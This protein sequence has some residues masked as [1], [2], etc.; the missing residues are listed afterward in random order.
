[1]LRII[2]AAASLFVAA[3]GVVA[4]MA[5][6][7]V[8]QPLATTGQT[9]S[10]ATAMILLAG[11]ALLAVGVTGW[12]GRP[13]GILG[14]LGF[15][16][17]AAW[18][19]PEL[20]GSASVT[21]EARSLGLLLA[22][23]FVPLVAH[24]PLR[25]LRVDRPGSLTG[26]LLAAAYGLVLVGAVGR[27]LTYD[28]F[29]EVACSPVCTRGDNVLAIHVE[30]R[31]AST[32]GTIALVASTALAI[33]LMAW[34]FVRLIRQSRSDRRR[35]WQ[36]L[37]PTV[38][39]GVGLGW[40]GLARIVV[41]GDSPANTWMLL[42]A[43]ITAASVTAL[44]AGV[45]WFLMTQL[46]QAD[47]LH[48]MAELMALESA[49][50]LR[51][52]LA[53][54][55]GDPELRVVYPLETRGGYVDE[56]GNVV[57]EPRRGHGR[58]VTAIERDG[59]VVAVVEHGASLDPELL[60]R[61]IGAAAR[62]A[63]DNE[64]LDAVVRARLRELQASRTR[65]VE[66]GDAARGRLERDLH[67]GAQ[68]RLLAVSFELRLAGAAA[69]GAGAGERVHEAFEHAVAETD[70]ALSELRDL[71][72]GIYPVVLTEDG[73]GSA[74]ASLAEESRLP[75]VVQG[76][77]DERCPGTTEVAAYVAVTESL[78]RAETADAPRV[79]VSL[80]RRGG[81]LTLD[82]TAARLGDA[83]WLRVEDRVGAAG[84]GTRIEQGSDGLTTLH[85]ELPCA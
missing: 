5:P 74:L 79:T 38:A 11:A 34:A 3:G 17:G 73:L 8:R 46:R 4:L 64:R 33:G 1:V 52:T 40:V 44:G 43:V 18:L 65:I 28:P 21:R 23:L 42:P 41:S 70:R 57:D 54:T 24:L 13:D 27:A 16:A 82:V 76:S 85:V 49:G 48:R 63:V 77:A 39:L 32:F 58:R 25:T 31:L 59:S 51:A 56:R 50:G 68:Q 36:V 7:I 61:E 60:D 26:L 37:V 47:A 83:G 2:G 55:L 71:A 19:A 29:F 67:D 14:V 72:H 30:P 12:F 22:P 15:A 81:W 78:R 9:G 69:T 10:E 75:L 62:L 84:G 6:A 53:R 45:T 35:E 66:A 80:G 20:A